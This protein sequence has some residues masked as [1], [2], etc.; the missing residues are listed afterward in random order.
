[1]NN[2]LNRLKLL[3]PRT[4]DAEIVE[5]INNTKVEK[6]IINSGRKENQRFVFRIIVQQFHKKNQENCN[7]RNTSIKYTRFPKKKKIVSLENI[8]GYI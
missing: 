6:S 3:K 2:L 4:T 8:E 5:N 7:T 1:M